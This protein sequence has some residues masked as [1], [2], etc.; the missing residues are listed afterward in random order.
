[1]IPKGLFTQIGMMIV[2]VAI[3]FTYIK[4]EFEKIS[5]I[6]DD[7]KEYKD[8][9]AMVITVN[10]TLD[11]LMSKVESV[12]ISDNERLFN[13]VPDII[14]EISVPRDLYLI[15]NEAGVIYND[16]KYEGIDAEMASIA[17]QENAESILAQTP[18]S[19]TLILSVEGSYQQIK[20]LLSLLEQNH[21]P[22]EVREMDI[23]S[24][25]GGFLKAEITLNTYS[26]RKFVTAEEIIF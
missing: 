17:N 15:S 9:R 18:V 21:Y 5:L 10:S 19:H 1:M 2:A 23:S 3:I 24:G 26:Y 13:Y 4:P 12:S 11:K 22:L 6:Q 20:K 7:I 16:T 25:E 8:Q 14:D